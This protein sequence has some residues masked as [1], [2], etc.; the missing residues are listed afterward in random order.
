MME[1]AHAGTVVI[2]GNEMGRGIAPR[3]S[4]VFCFVLF[5]F[6]KKRVCAILH[7][8]TYISFLLAHIHM[9]VIL[10]FNE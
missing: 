10:I 5:F 7:K 9:Y 2:F 3:D 6:A 8:R 4:G 1:T